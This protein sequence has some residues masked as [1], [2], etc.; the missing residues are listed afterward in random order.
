[1]VGLAR[2]IGADPRLGEFGE[3]DGEV[4]V[5]AGI[6]DRPVPAPAF[7]W[8]LEGVETYLILRLLGADLGLVEVMSFDAALS[9]VRSAAVFAPAGIGVQDLGYL[10]VLEA[11]GV[12]GASGIA[13][14]FVVLKRMKEALFVAVG[15]IVI[16]RTGAARKFL[17]HASDHRAHADSAAT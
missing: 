5:G 7:L 9:V 4:D 16:A 1:V 10:A 12:P 6:V 11:Y 3:P 14:A 17:H 13:P 2:R 8:L 15:F